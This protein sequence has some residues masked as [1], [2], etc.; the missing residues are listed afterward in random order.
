MGLR[1]ARILQAQERLH[2]MHNTESTGP[3]LP[4]QLQVRKE[5]NSPPGLND[6]QVWGGWCQCISIIL[7][8][9]PVQIHLIDPII[10]HGASATKLTEGIIGEK[11]LLFGQITHHTIGPVQ[12]GSLEKTRS[13]LPGLRVSPVRTG[14]RSHFSSCCPRSDS[15]PLSVQYT[16]VSGI[17]RIS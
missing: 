3:Q 13:V 12:H 7:L 9:F 1:A 2:P 5:R 8:G 4:V 14:S 11:N 10:V 17:S 6:D 15:T 16:G